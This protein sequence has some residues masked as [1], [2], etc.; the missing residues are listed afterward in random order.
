MGDNSLL[1]GGKERGRYKKAAL[2]IREYA[3]RL[4]LTQFDCYL[5][6]FF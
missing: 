5:C 3:E 2:Y 4:E 6:A 1:I